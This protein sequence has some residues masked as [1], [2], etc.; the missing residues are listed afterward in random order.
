[1]S[2]Y[3]TGSATCTVKL[4]FLEG[5][6]DSDGECMIGQRRGREAVVRQDERCDGEHT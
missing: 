1:M 2:F 4:V 3:S 5:H 6:A